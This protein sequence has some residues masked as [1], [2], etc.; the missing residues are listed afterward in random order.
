[1]KLDPRT[2]SSEQYYAPEV[3]ACRLGMDIN[4]TADFKGLLPRNK[5]VSIYEELA[6]FGKEILEKGDIP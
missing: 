5:L 1:M 4:T 6:V 2:R 3:Y